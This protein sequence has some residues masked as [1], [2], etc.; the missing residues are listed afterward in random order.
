LIM[1]VVPEDTRYRSR[2]PWAA[3][4][5]YAVDIQPLAIEIVKKSRA[6]L[7]TNIKT[8]LVDSYDTGFQ[9]QLWI[10]YC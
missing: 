7:L 9:A 10:W 3:G 2:R 4:A 1:P 8:I 6:N 5:V